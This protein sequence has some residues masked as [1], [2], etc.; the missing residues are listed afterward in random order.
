M[1]HKIADFKNTFNFSP[2]LQK[3]MDG[4]E[5]CRK[6]ALSSMTMGLLITASHI[7]RYVSKNRDY[8]QITTYVNKS[9]GSRPYL[10]VEAEKEG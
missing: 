9:W 7:C 4:A 6:Y 10:C 2:L 1:C 5:T 3:T 8:K